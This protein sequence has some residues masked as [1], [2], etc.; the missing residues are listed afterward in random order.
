MSFDI[1]T[2][3]TDRTANDV[4]EGT[5][6]G[7]YNASDLNRVG[8]AMIYLSERFS[9]Y[10]YIVHVSP[11]TDWV[12][13]DIPTVEQMADYLDNIARLRKVYAV[14]QGTPQV[15][16]SMEN[17]TFE[18]AN[19][20]EQ[21]LAD[22]ECVIER[23]MHAFRRCGSFGFWSGANPFPS[24]NND[25]GRTWEELD[26]MET[27]WTNWQVADWYLLLYGNLEAE[28]ELE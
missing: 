12:M 21:I 3:I 28:G 7:H 9:S 22:I 16:P 17:L 6:K 8:H 25:M 18:V 10:G 27:E 11:K 14:L 15:P 26:A 24:V 5:D 19:D 4:Q 1:S 23:V 13:E 20:I 2:L